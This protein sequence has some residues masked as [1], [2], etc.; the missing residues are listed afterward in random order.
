MAQA[1]ASE[2]VPTGFLPRAPRSVEE[3]GLN[4]GF[5][6]DLALKVLYFE[7]FL[8]GY[9]LAERM[10]LPYAGVVDQVLEFLKREKLCEVKG[11]G[12][13]AEA[14]YQYA[15]SDKG[16]LMAREA[17]DR[18]HYAGPAPVPLAVY[19]DAIRQQSLGQIVV[20]QRTMR[21]A[22]SHLVISEEVFAQLAPP[23]TPASPF[24]SSA[25][26]ATARRS[27][28]RPSAR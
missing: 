9:E 12:G 13:F 10:K 23:S 2:V 8:S 14:A 11:A 16:R 15:I 27:S 19:S 6:I 17:L 28:L 20:H 4:L 3:T 21:Q 24:S 5:L 26:R 7:G 22:L 25:L 18:S 1:S